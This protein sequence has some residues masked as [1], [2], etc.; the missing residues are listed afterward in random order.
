MSEEKTTGNEATPASDVSE[1]KGKTPE[2]KK[3]RDPVKFWTSIVLALCVIIFV[4]HLFSD[5]YTPYTSNGRIE[6]FIVPIAPEVSGILSQ[7][8]VSNNQIVSGDQELAIIDPAKYKLAVERAK[9]DLQQASQTSAADVSSVTTAQA[10]VAE[11]EANLR[12]AEVKGQRI[13]TL[14][15]QGAASL[16]RADDAR[17]SIEAKKAKLDSARSELEK[18]KSNLGAIGQDNARIRTALAALEVAPRS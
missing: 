11:A 12:N 13:I 3:K 7:V 5:K 2:E 1:K 8:Y 18:A 10:R 17:S 6:A 9:A 14:S 15:K 16:S 4:W